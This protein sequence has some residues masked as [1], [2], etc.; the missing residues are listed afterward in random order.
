MAKAK[1]LPSGNWRVKLFLGRVD[2]KSQFK[3]FTAE[4]AKEAEYAA[5]EYQLNNQ[6]HTKPSDMTLGE[7]IGKYI[8]IKS[9]VLSPSTIKAYDI[10]SKT[11]I[12]NIKNIK[13]SKLT[14]ETIQ[15]EINKLAADHKPKTVRNIHG[16]ISATLKM[17]YPSFKLHTTLP[18]RVKNDIDIPTEDEI[19]QILNYVKGTVMEIP[20]YLAACCGMRRSEIIGLKWECINIKNKTIRIKEAK[21]K[22]INNEMVVKGTKETASYRTIRVY[23][24]VIEAL[25]AEKEKS[26]SE[27]ITTLT[28]QAI[29]DRF[30]AIL[31]KLSI[32]HYR[33]HDL[34]HYVASAML[35]LNIPKNYIAAYLGHASENMV[36]KVYGHI[37]A[38]KKSTVD[39]QLEQYF[40]ELV[41]T[42]V[43]TL[44]K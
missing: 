27:Y 10:I 21:V 8:N 39:D 36:D 29:Y 2:G 5:L 17:Y 7:A 41:S 15:I 20:M 25:K 13:L 24:F 18:Q 23:P 30:E 9:N 43:S 33:L 19:K 32:Q 22:D 37:M 26:S 14:H 28:G 34:R 35:S 42:N 44:K 11:N 38:S 31:E 16:L 12:E 4:T 6:E 3:S 40:S 1:K